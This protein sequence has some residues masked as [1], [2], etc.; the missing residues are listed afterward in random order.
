VSSAA[1]PVSTD[2]A[3]RDAE[4][5]ESRRVE[6]PGILLGRAPEGRNIAVIYHFPLNQQPI[7][8]T[9]DPS[10]TENALTF[11]LQDCS[12]SPFLQ[13]VAKFIILDKHCP[14]AMMN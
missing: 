2:T 5:Q 4:V 1:N 12:Y 14:R 3:L 8:I 9:F 11:V 10:V 6:S 7:Q 13:Q